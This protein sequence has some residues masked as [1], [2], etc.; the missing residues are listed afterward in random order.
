[1]D[2]WPRTGRT[3]VAAQVVALTNWSS[4]YA[5]DEAVRLEMCIAFLERH[6]AR[7][8]ERCLE[9]LMAHAARDRLVG[10]R[11]ALVFSR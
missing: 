7:L 8:A 2:P 3:A 9:E 5:R 10:A 6:E 1:M 11:V 4:A